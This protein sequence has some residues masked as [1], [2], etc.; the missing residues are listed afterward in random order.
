MSNKHKNVFKNKSVP[1][2]AT[3]SPVN[4][5]H[6]STTP[7]T[8]IIF[9]TMELLSE[10]IFGSGFSIPGGEDIAVCYDEEGYP[11]LKG[12]T[13][14]G[15][16]R[17]SLE[18]I[19]AWTNREESE[20]DVLL[21][22]SGWDGV[23]DKCRIHLTNL[24]LPDNFKAEHPA[25]SCFSTR[26][27]TSIENGVVKAKTLR[28][29]TCI[30]AGLKFSGELICCSDD[31]NLIKDSLRGIKWVGTMRSRG[32]GR[33]RFIIG[34]EKRLELTDVIP[35]L[36]NTR[37]IRYRLHSELPIL[38]T[39][40]NRSCGNSFETRGY[41]PG[42]VIRGMV[43][44]E[45]SLTAPQ[46]FEKSK[47]T[48]LSDKTRFLD[49]FP[50]HG[51]YAVLPSIKG[52]YEDKNEEKF[53]SVVIDGTFSAGSKRAK[54]GNFCA[55]EDETIRYW[56]ADTGGV[57]RIARNVHGEEDTQMFQ[58]RYLNAGQE[59]E[60]WIILDDPEIAPEISKV[61]KND[62][63]IGADR[64]EG[65]G[66]CSV[67]ALDT[68]E[69]PSI[70]SRYGCKSQD[71]I[72]TVLYMLAVTP[73]TMLDENGDPCG[74]DVDELTRLL[75]INK[76]KTKIAFCSTSVS[77]YGSY[78]R[79]WKCREPSMRMYDP[80]S[81]FKLIFDEPPNLSCMQAVQNHGLGVRRAEGYG[82]VLFISRYGFESLRLK[83]PIDT[84]STLSA[85]N[86][87]R[88]AE[89]RRAKICWVESNCSSLYNGGLSKSQLGKIQALC[90]K[91]MLN[92][93]IKD[94][95]DLFFQ[96]NLEDR[97]AAHKE[98]LISIKAFI[99]S[100][101]DKPIYETLGL[102][103]ECYDNMIERFKLL[104]L[105]FD[106]SRKEKRKKVNSDGSRI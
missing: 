29:A 103:H 77:E 38:I 7:E 57:T 84:S 47:I 41:I 40:P 44:S 66:R 93:G 4:N 74:I 3:L 49:A 52:F 73:L 85:G 86:I 98:R 94:E 75:G 105:L 36:P 28:T 64:Y 102:K 5:V 97:G 92:D 10:A 25:E 60:G 71:E 21:G 78:N 9:I 45:L 101:L 26:T 46:W 51:D 88:A 99:D 104:C 67:T 69:C 34:A 58:T 89:L 50:C 95:L 19:L 76:G 62:I 37:C 43:I 79:T 20:A 90:E 68:A 14:K 63:W 56:S 27:F 61:F 81:V 83:K 42:S 31:C 15:L 12:T 100:T 72:G 91:A 32:F 65:F 24:T 18:N 2:N 106:Y 70:I 22:E 82:Q 30:Q 48:L 39:D 23:A 96:K 87:K 13:L 17:E 35:S 33:V 6:T 11:Y 59:F 80:G 1:L 8:V 53:E 55:L 16:I 54:L